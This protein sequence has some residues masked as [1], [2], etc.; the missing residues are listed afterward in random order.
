MD[1]SPRTI[2]TVEKGGILTVFS[3]DQIKSLCDDLMNGK[4]RSNRI[5]LWQHPSTSMKLK[6]HLK[7][8]MLHFSEQ[9]T[10][11][12]LRAI[13]QCTG[14]GGRIKKGEIQLLD[15]VFDVMVPEITIKVL[16]AKD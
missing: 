8:R 3:K 14:I 11:E 15:F 1:D 9:R 7:P 5:Y 6:Q 10:F 2:E 13:K 4:I 12:L 16:D